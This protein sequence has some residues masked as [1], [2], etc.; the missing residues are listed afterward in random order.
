MSRKPRKQSDQRKSAPQSVA[1]P[2]APRTAWRL[3]LGS[4]GA[5]GLT[6]AVVWAVAAGV[7]RSATMGIA[8]AASN[9]GFTVRQVEIEGA[10]N[11]PR[12]SI[13][14]ELLQGGSDSMLLADLDGVDPPFRPAIATGQVRDQVG[15]GEHASPE[16]GLARRA[17]PARRVA[18]AHG[19]D[20]RDRARRRDAVAPV[21]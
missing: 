10:E 4:V 7:P 20:E 16:L 5:L 21:G 18:A 3:I 15:G 17:V 19:E 6:A 9:A 14:R 8:T 1:I 11:Q 2:V 12:L 13:Y